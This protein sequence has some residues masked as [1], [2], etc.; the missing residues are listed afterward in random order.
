MN[1][2]NAKLGEILVRAGV[3]TEQQ[4]GAALE[5]QKTSKLRLGEQLIAGGYIT[6]EQLCRALQEQMH[7][8][9]ID[10]HNLPIDPAVPGLI[11]EALAR[12]ANMLPFERTGNTLKLAVSDPLDYSSVRD[13]EIQTGLDAEIYICERSRIAEKIHEIYTNAKVFE[14]ART[15]AASNAAEQPAEQINIDD[16]QPLIR[17]VNNMFEQAVILKASDIHIEPGPKTMKVRFRVDGKLLDYI[18]TSNEIFPSVCSRIKFIGGMS[19]AEKRIPQDGRATYNSGSHSIDLRLSTLPSIFG[20]KIVIRITT[21]LTFALKKENLG[22]SDHNLQVFDALIRKPYGIVLVT[23]PTG[24]GKSTTLYTALSEIK[25]SDI[26]IVTVEN[27]VEMIVPGITQVNINPAQ[28]LTFPAVLR[29]VLRQDP[30]VVMIGEIRDGETAE[31]ASSMAIT[32]HLVFSTLH[33]Y[34]APSAVVRLVDMGIQP[35]MVASSVIGVI[36]QRL[37]RCLCPKCRET[38]AASEAE[39]KLLGVP[40]AQPLLLYRAVG[41]PACAGTGYAG[42]TAIGEIMT[43]SARIRAAVNRSASSDELRS[44]AISEGMRTIAQDARVVVMEGRTTLAEAAALV[45]FTGELM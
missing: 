45:D 34:D 33:T 16:E 15:M 12:A 20:E 17:F 35:F 37:V 39:K 23:G 13:I 38:Y 4:L 44:I 22:F 26:N 29:S 25:R 1:F 24:S 3:L 10:L 19:I 28:G 31:I 11:P 42:R 7:L 18:T 2:F 43:V 6:E 40:A 5:Q 14:A 32:G 30:D 8:K 9:Y 36:S 41:C 21:S 27:P